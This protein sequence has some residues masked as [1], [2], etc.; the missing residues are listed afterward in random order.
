MELHWR[1]RLADHD[2]LDGAA[3]ARAIHDLP[4]CGG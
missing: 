2:P 1:S 4:H 3:V